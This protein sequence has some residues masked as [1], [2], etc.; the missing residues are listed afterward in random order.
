M[1]SPRAWL[2]RGPMVAQ[3]VT[4]PV[5]GVFRQVGGSLAGRISV[6]AL[7]A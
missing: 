3:A 1:R 5:A 4:S 6:E 2:W 7:A